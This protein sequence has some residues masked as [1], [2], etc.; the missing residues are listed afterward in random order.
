MPR[1]TFRSDRLAAAHARTVKRVARWVDVIWGEAIPPQHADHQWKQW[2]V[3]V[4]WKNPSYREA[5]QRWIREHRP[6]DNPFTVGMFAQ[7]GRLPVRYRR[8][9]V[10]DETW[11]TSELF[12][13]LRTIELDDMLGSY[14]VD[15]HSHLHIIGIVRDLGQSPFGE[16]ERRLLLLQQRELMP[17]MGNVLA[18]FDRPTVADMAPRLRQT[19]LCLLQ[20]KSEKQ[21]AIRM[22]ISPATVHEYVKQLHRH[23]GVSSRGELLSRSIGLF[24]VLATLEDEWEKHYTEVPETAVGGRGHSNM[25]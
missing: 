20:G 22:G 24:S 11:Y 25:R 7:Q 12:Q 4:G 15:H 18:N 3:D 9:I 19:L 10:D 23:F 8:Q 2:M 6:E 1:V 14:F 21:A 16:R 17:L 5:Y 13:L